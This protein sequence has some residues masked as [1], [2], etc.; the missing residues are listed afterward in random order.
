MKCGEHV[1]N[2]TKPEWPAPR[3]FE[4]DLESLLD[5]VADLALKSGVVHDGLALGDFDDEVTLI[6][7]K[8][9]Q[10]CLHVPIE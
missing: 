2:V 6:E 8:V 3:S 9:R 4:R 5:V 1:T 10:L 7:P